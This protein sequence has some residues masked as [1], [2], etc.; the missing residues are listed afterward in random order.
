MSIENQEYVVQSGNHWLNSD[1]MKEIISWTTDLC[2][3]SLFTREWAIGFVEEMERQG[4]HCDFYLFETALKKVR[5]QQA[6]EHKSKWLY[7]FYDMAVEKYKERVTETGIW[8]NGHMYYSTCMT[9][10]KAVERLGQDLK[11]V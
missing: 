5:D 4:R 6:S 9:I 10:P 7:R 1:E 8:V 3:A 2:K 11:L